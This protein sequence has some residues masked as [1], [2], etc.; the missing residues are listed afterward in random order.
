MMN[1]P[2][3]G[4][5]PDHPKRS[6]RPIMALLELLGRRWALRIIWELRNGPLSARALRSSCDNAS[7]TVLHA[8]LRELRQAGLVE[9][10]S[11][12]GYALT[13]RGSELMAAFE[14]LYAFAEGRGFGL[15]DGPLPGDPDLAGEG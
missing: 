2:S 4:T 5:P 12:R 9:L 11:G 8:R 15:T 6:A 1:H 13:G 7:P 14:P 3:S 10:L